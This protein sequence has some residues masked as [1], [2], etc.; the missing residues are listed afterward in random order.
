MSL[1][2]ASFTF[3]PLI[4][5]KYI[6]FSVLVLI[7]LGSIGYWEMTQAGYTLILTVEK[8]NGV[9]IVLTT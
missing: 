6:Y 3:R 7:F 1:L 4:S 5:G 8:E 9:I 2:T